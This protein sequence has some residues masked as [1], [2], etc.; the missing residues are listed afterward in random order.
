MSTAGLRVAKNTYR[1]H[2]IAC[3]YH[4]G[5]GDAP[6]GAAGMDGRGVLVLTLV[7]VLQRF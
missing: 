6:G 2:K 7:I 5:G 4:R 1:W 3:L